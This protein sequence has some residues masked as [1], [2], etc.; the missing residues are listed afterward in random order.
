[1]KSH[2][3]EDSVPDLLKNNAYQKNNNNKYLT[4]TSLAVQQLRHCT[5]TAG[6]VDSIT[7]QGTKISYS[8]WHGQKNKQ[9]IIKP[10]L[11]Q[12]LGILENTLLNTYHLLGE[13]Q[14]I[15]TPTQWWWVTTALGFSFSIS[16]METTP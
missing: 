5:P 16:A 1:M 11:L 14:L 8:V 2:E 15:S 9:I 6:G 12:V 7:G 13:R 4:T 3:E 10:N